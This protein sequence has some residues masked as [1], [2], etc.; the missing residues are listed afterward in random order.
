MPH[1]NAG[2]LA[3]LSISFAFRHSLAFPKPPDVHSPVAA[4][5]VLCYQGEEVKVRGKEVGRGFNFHVQGLK[6]KVSEVGEEELWI[7]GWKGKVGR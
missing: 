7:P 3:P 2:V 5:V 6:S 1:S 4:L